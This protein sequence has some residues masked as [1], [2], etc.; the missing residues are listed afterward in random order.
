[1]KRWDVLFEWAGKK[2][3]KWVDRVWPQPDEN[4]STLPDPEAEIQK[5]IM[6]L[7]VL[8]DGLQ[9]SRAFIAKL[10]ADLAESRAALGKSDQVIEGLSKKS[11]ELNTQLS[12]L[13]YEQVEEERLL[14]W[15]RGITIR[16]IMVARKSG[17]KTR[18]QVD[19]QYL[20]FLVESLQISDE[21]LEDTLQRMNSKEVYEAFLAFLKQ[22]FHNPSTDSVI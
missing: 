6:R 5:L 10:E 20:S 16:Y 19:D 12:K 21:E 8:E 1:M 15:F 18:R 4:A 13:G 22:H 17:W 14:S 2:A 11:A 9:E 7:P 3:R